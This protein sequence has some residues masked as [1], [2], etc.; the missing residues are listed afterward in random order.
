MFQQ[1][2][3]CENDYEISGLIQGGEFHHMNVYRL[4]KKKSAPWSELMNLSTQ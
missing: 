1:R 2:A 3:Y 4:M